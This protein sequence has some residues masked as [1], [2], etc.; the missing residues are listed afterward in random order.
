LLG[1]FPGSESDGDEAGDF[2]LVHGWEEKP[3][4]RWAGAEAGILRLLPGMDIEGAE[5]NRPSGLDPAF[6]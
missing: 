4:D 5:K 3:A 1:I 2:N 6:G